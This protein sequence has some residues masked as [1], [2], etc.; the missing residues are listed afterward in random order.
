M[1][2]R[3][4]ISACFCQYLCPFF[5]SAF[6]VRFYLFFLAL[7]PFFPHP[8]CFYRNTDKA[9]L[10]TL[11]KDTNSICFIESKIKTENST[12]N[13]KSNLFPR[14]QINCPDWSCVILWICFVK[15]KLGLVGL[16][17]IRVIFWIFDFSMALVSEPKPN[18]CRVMKGPLW[19]QFLAVYTE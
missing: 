12:A 4:A 18:F 6:S 19:K 15:V 7:C 1:L 11:S 17:L 5:R 13:Q 16:I 2:K 8:F 10:V 3:N 14:F 9:K